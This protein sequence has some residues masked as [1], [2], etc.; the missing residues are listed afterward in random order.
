VHV[1]VVDGDRSCR[2]ARA[3]DRDP[4]GQ[5]DLGRCAKAGK[6]GNGAAKPTIERATGRCAGGQ[7]GGKLRTRGRR[8]RRSQRSQEL[9]CSSE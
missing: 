1:V 6:P 2:A 8:S 4:G 5:H 3:G 7:Q 9:G